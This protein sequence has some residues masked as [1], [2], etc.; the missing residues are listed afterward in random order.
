MNAQID[1][2]VFEHNFFIIKGKVSVAAAMNYSIKFNATTS[3]KG[4]LKL[5]LDGYQKT[6]TTD[7]KIRD[8]KGVSPLDEA[9]WILHMRGAFKADERRSS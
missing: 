1:S 6:T 3:G 9:Q 2:P 7:D 8:Y 4:R 5:T